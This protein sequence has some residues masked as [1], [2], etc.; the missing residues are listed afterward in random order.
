MQEIMQKE[1]CWLVK[2]DVSFTM[3]GKDGDPMQV[4]VCC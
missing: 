2:Q 4:R 3:P 1:D